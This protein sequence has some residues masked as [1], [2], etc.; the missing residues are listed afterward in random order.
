[1]LRWQTCSLLYRYTSLKNAVPKSLC[2]L[3]SGNSPYAQAYIQVVLPMGSL[4]IHCTVFY[5]TDFTKWPGGKNHETVLPVVI[6]KSLWAKFCALTDFHHI[7]FKSIPFHSDSEHHLVKMNFILPSLHHPSTLLQFLG[8]PLPIHGHRAP[9]L[10]YFTEAWRPAWESRVGGLC[11]LFPCFPM[12]RILC[13][14]H[15]K[16]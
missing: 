12:R 3:R 6:F 9:T 16:T 15:L 4:Q 1:M 8:T 2:G 5:S 14:S 13:F 11:D 7:Y 10:K